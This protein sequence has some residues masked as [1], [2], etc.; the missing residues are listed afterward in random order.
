MYYIVGCKHKYLKEEHIFLKYK[1]ALILNICI[2]LDVHGHLFRLPFDVT[3]RTFALSICGHHKQ[4]KIV[5]Q[6][7][8]HHLLY[9]F[10]EQKI[11]TKFELKKIFLLYIILYIF[12]YYI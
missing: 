10:T 3:L 4:R 7:I 12:I 1:Y 5:S 6:S 8:S 11:Y 9:K 2:R